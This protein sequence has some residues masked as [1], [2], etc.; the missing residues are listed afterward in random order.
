MEGVFGL[1]RFCWLTH[2]NSLSIMGTQW[3]RQVRKR[4]IMNQSRYKPESPPNQDN[5]KN[6]KKEVPSKV[7]QHSKVEAEVKSKGMREK[8]PA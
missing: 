3:Q 5:L 7:L 1:E 8:V 2:W 4:D 6:H